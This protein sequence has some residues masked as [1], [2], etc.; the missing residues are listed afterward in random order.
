M[1]E[2]LTMRWI[3]D[4]IPMRAPMHVVEE[5]IRMRIED[6]RSR[7]ADID[8]DREEELVQQAKSMHREKRNLD[9]AAWCLRD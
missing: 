9:Y 1:N 5:E 6:A 7:G 2:M 3:V 4:E 8:E